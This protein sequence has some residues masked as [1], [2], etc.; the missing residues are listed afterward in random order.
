MT[1]LTNG[2][3]SIVRL[4]NMLIEYYVYL[5]YLTVKH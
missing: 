1:I 3:G 4:P 2:T 5:D